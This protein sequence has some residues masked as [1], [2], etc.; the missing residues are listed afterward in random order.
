MT[1][2]AHYSEC[3]YPTTNLHGFNTYKNKISF[4]YKT[5]TLYVIPNSQSLDS[6]VGI[7][8]TLSAGWLP[9]ESL[10]PF[11]TVIV[12]TLRTGLLNC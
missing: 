2:V 12:N 6:S 7:V 3:P 4:T 9:D 11:M 10:L 5:E 8:T 1:D